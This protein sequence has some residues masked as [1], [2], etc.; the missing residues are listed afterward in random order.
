ML[1]NLFS[2]LQQQGLITPDELDNVAVQQQRPLSVRN[3]LLTL[4]YAGIVVLCTGLGIVVYQNIDSI[5]H[6]AIIAFIAI[7]CTACYVW[8]FKKASGYSQAKVQSPN[9]GFD[10]VILFGSLLLLIWVGYMQF[11]YHVFGERW[12]LAGFVPMVLLFATA[13]YFD[14]AGVLSLG[15][16]NLAAWLGITVAPLSVV[17]GNDFGNERLIYT[18]VLLGAFLVGIAAFS[19]YKNVKKHFY[20]V[21]LN[22]GTHLFFI[23]AVTAM[24][25]FHDAYFLWFVLIAAAAAACLKYAV[26]ANS[27]YYFA[28]TI[29]YSY[30]AAMYAGIALLA[31]MPNE[32]GVIYLGLLYGISLSVLLTWLLI[33]YNKKFKAHA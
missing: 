27:Y 24:F 10:Y 19:F 5:G 30:A 31:L 1:Y 17:S 33:H 20:K 13:Y 16:S 28:V 18:A 9:T 23:G 7:T 32:V 11:V 14:H 26:A 29:A 8:C 2:K 15:I 3:D 12:G 25:V 22:F 6:M 4:L 21:Y